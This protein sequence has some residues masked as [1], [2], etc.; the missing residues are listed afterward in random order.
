MARAALKIAVVRPYLTIKKG[1]A[2]RYAME[3]IRALAEAGHTVHAFAC[4]WD[5][6]EQPGVVYHRVSMPR[7]PAWL[8]VLCFHLSLRRRLRRT[9]YDVVF[10]LAPFWPQHVFWLGDGLYR[11]WVR[12]AW[13]LAPVRWLMCL[14][15]AVMAVNLMMERKILTP[16]TAGIIANS[17][18]VARQARQLYGVPAEHIAV[19]YPW[20]DTQRFNAAARPR[21]RDA[22]RR[23]L[24]IHEDESALLFASNNFARKGLAALLSALAK[25]DRRAAP[26]RL[27]VAGAGAVARFRRRAESLGLAECTTFVGAVADMERYYA[28]ADVFVL[29]TRY[30]PCATVCLEAMA[31]GLPVITTEMNGAAE[32]IE[33]GKTGFVLGRHASVDALASSIRSW[34][35]GEWHAC[36]AAEV[37]ARVHDLSTAAHGRRIVAA[38]ESFARSEPNTPTVQIEPSLAVNETFL[39]LLKQH[40][41]TSF[42]ALLNTAKRNEIEY[43]QNKRIALLALERREEPIFLFLKA[44]RQER[45]WAGATLGWRGRTEGIKE[46]QNI[47]TL[48]SAGIP[49]ATPVAAGE[50]IVSDGSRESFVMTLRLDGYMPL[51]QY[52]AARYTPPLSSALRRDKR[53]LIRAVAALARRMHGSGF[54][55]QDFY[56]CH[57]FVKIADSGLPDLRLIDLQRVGHR[58][59][60][61]RRWVIK[62]LAQ[63]HYSSLGLPLSDRE[64][65][66]FF[67]NYRAPAR[68][69]RERRRMI[70][71][72]LRKSRGI[73]K[74]DEKLRARQPGATRDPFSISAALPNDS[75]HDPS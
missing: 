26:L 69:R 61:A 5:K 16:A 9:D 71:R 56:L 54:N 2:E 55:H 50:R 53:A 27:I 10:G 4:A 40:R 21:W 72:I 63:L 57:I 1:G 19:I 37:A 31:C 24:G 49:T 70:R 28:A 6:P 25:I 65:L 18:L 51:D 74:H 42:T 64:R 45:P 41:L 29:P 73:A 75:R 52:I 7:K 34:A 62:D 39:P 58:R 20:I 59:F 3:S 13:P 44:H 17:Q 30:D 33:D 11:V 46:W 8:R 60:P 38:L 48:Q 66:W 36:A 15:R 32:F 22:M 68:D 14:K 35:S 67:C 12:I 47:L 23:Q 43:N